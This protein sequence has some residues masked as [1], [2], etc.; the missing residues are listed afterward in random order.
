MLIADS[1]YRLFADKAN[2]KY[3]SGES[4]IL[5][6]VTAETQLGK[7]NLQLQD[8]QKEI[9]IS[10]LEFMLLLNTDT[11]YEP[12]IDEVKFNLPSFNDSLVLENHPQI[13]VFE[14][15]KEIASR[16]IK[17]EKSRLMPEIHLGYNNTSMRGVGA[18]DLYYPR[19]NRFSSIG[20][21][22]GI[23]LFFTAQH[24]RIKASGLNRTIAENNYRIQFQNL[25][26]QYNR[27]LLDFKNNL[28]K[29]NYYELT[30]IPDAKIIANSARDQFSSGAIDYL[31]WL[32]L[33][34]AA[35]NIQI[36]YL[37]AI[38]SF[39]ESIIEINYL[40]TKQE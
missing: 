36:E 4:N 28:M 6:K 37:D 3:M 23:P 1:T 21:G 30:A 5:E 14:Q 16:A 7:I 33:N 29:I 11:K 10:L 12:A 17:L 15:E 35:V 18:D 34:N 26:Q 39:N 24:A 32:M 22:I 25:N 27:A 19:S 2:N 13:K 20:A 38:R 8:I 31:D 40:T 9:E